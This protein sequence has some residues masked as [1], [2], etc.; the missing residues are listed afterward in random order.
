MDSLLTRELLKARMF[1]TSEASGV[2]FPVTVTRSS[3][4]SIAAQ[5]CNSLGNPRFVASH[6]GSLADR[7]P[8]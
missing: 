4:I 7:H 8:T 5:S 3:L 6:F 2:S 1:D